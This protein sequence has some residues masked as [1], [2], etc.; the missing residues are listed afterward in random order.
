LI[1]LY[2]IIEKINQ[3]DTRT[4]FIAE[5]R[6]IQ[7]YPKTILKVYHF[8]PYV[9][10]AEKERQI[11]S[12]FHDPE[13]MRMIPLHPN[14]IR[15]SDMFAWEHDKFVLPTEYLEHGRTLETLLD[16]KEDRQMTWREKREVIVRLARGLRHA[17][18]AGII[19]RDVR[20]LSV[21]VAPNDQV[22][23][24]NFDLAFIQQ[25][26]ELS[27]PLNL[28]QRL[29]PFYTAPEVWR[30]PASASEASDV[31]ALGLLFYELITHTPPAFE[32]ETVIETQTQPIDL[33]CLLHEL[34]QPGSQDFM[35]SPLD[36]VD[37]I[38]KMCAF[39]PHERYANMDGVLE[40][41]SIVGD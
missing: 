11:Q 35:A 32:V 20:P 30:D 8:D 33:E 41:L 4:V 10:A 19:H 9:S 14:I 13:V 25:A 37:I 18:R 29:H 6:Y 38:R 7:T 22:K 27:A 2:N 40:D 15:S 5:H 16:R 24:V 23:L 21:V 1:G 17:H 12:I 3:T 39:A 34:S 26:P 36:A 31:Y 28:R